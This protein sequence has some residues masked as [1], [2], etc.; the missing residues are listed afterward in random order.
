MA[1]CLIDAWEDL[2]G[3]EIRVGLTT[4][5]LKP[6]LIVVSRGTGHVSIPVAEVLRVI[7]TMT[8]TAKVAEERG[9]QFR[10]TWEPVE[11]GDR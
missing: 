2:T 11:E 1:E 7:D 3:R 10:Q 5:H 9:A 8:R 6:N 4:Y